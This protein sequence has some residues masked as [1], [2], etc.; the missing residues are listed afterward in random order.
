V[1]SLQ[2][3]LE[4]N[5]DLLT[6]EMQRF[7]EGQARLSQFSA[8]AARDA[9]QRIEQATSALKQSGTAADNRGRQ[10]RSAAQGYSCAG[11]EGG[12]SLTPAKV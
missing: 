2:Q 7:F 6:G 9:K 5:I 10:S 3:L 1:R 11:P 12:M 8:E 4:V